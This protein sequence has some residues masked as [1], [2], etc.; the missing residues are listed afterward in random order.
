MMGKEMVLETSVLYRHFM[1]LT[2]REDFIEK[3]SISPK[4]LFGVLLRNRLYVKCLEEDTAPLYWSTDSGVL[5]DPF[6]KRMP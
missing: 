1:R 6:Y 5:F 2:V 3:E 4:K